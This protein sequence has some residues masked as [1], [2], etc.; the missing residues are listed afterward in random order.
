MTDQHTLRLFITLAEQLHFGKTSRH[1]HMTVSA[2]SRAIQRMEKTLGTSLFERNNRQVK[3]T[4]AGEKFYRFAQETVAHYDTLQQ[5]LLNT[6]HLQGKLKLY[7]TVTAAYSILPS[8]IKTF[9]DTHPFIMTYLETGAAK[10]SHSRLL[11]NEVDFA[12][13]IITYPVIPELLCKKILET[14]L[15]FVVP[16]TSTAK[17][18]SDIDLIFPEQGDL[19][20]IITHYAKTQNISTQ[21]HSYVEG[22]EAILAMVAAGL[23]GALLPKIV[24]D[25][26]HL[27]KAVRL[28][29]VSA[30]L[31]L[32]EV[33]VF[34]KQTSLTSP[35]KHA[36]WE[37]C[38]KR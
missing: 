8:L 23:G 29:E 12:I 3:L 32:I 26:S 10:N 27:K 5:T 37:S 31:P 14:P 19:A 4:D 20:A 16:K 13:G 35:I 38:G 36:F 17:Q 6:D 11:N 1:H 30:P 33:G 9:R 24:I 25:N 2:L 15:V 21:I 18:I 34:M 7:S 22:H 28:I